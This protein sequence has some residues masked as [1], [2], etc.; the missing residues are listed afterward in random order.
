MFLLNSCSITS[1]RKGES[2]DSENISSSSWNIC[3]FDKIPNSSTRWRLHNCYQKLCFFCMKLNFEKIIFT[4]FPCNMFVL[5]VYNLLQSWKLFNVI[6]SF[7]LIYLYKLWSTCLNSAPYIDPWLQCSIRMTDVWR[8]E[9]PYARSL[10]WCCLPTS[11]IMV[12]RHESRTWQR[13]KVSW[14][15]CY[16]MYSFR[17]QL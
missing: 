4:L 10:F 14:I 8:L 9:S 2:V 7:F 5:F 17:I 11:V 1:D 3:W 16:V 12:G 15:I 13:F 6:Q